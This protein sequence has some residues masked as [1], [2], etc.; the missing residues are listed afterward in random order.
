MEKKENFKEFG[1]KLSKGLEEVKEKEKV[2]RALEK[3]KE[4]ME[5]NEELNKKIKQTKQE[6]PTLKNK[7]FNYIQKA[8]DNMAE[9]ARKQELK[10]K[11]DQTQQESYSDWLM[12]V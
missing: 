9:N 12:N 10:N 3:K 1:E 8:G 11:G 6:M 7:V 4:V 2:L 5:K